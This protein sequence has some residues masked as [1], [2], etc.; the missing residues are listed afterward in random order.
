MF[1][2]IDSMSVL[3]FTTMLRKLTKVANIV[4]FQIILT[5][6]FS[7]CFLANYL[8]FSVDDKTTKN[9]ENPAKANTDMPRDT[10]NISEE[11]SSDD[12]CSSKLSLV[13]TNSD[14]RDNPG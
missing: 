7:I 6:T 2:S 11:P 4:P 5:L 10:I 13:D 12:D 9:S 3:D 1:P 14:L 8:P